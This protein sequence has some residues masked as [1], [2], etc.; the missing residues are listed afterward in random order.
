MV[1]FCER[2]FSYFRS[3]RLRLGTASIFAAMVLFGFVVF[4]IGAATYSN[5]PKREHQNQAGGC[6]QNC[7]PKQPPLGSWWDWTTHDPVAFYTSVLSIFTGLLFVSTVGLWFSTRRGIRVQTDDTRILQRAYLS[8]SP[9][10]IEPFR[11]GDGRL[12][13]D[14]YFENSGNLPAQF[15]SWFINQSFSTDPNLADFP[16]NES[17]FVGNN[18]IPPHGKI[19]KGGPAVNSA[20]LDAFRGRQQGKPDSCWLYVWGRVKYLDGFNKPRFTD[21]CYRYYLTGTTWTIRPKHGRQHEYG[22]RTDEG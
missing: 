22:N 17:G 4:H 3:W 2:I 6:T 19:R 13:C 12:S 21:F 16:I 7:A 5:Y 1:G 14:L 8:V 18:L 9:G 10:G 11:S 15:V 20:E